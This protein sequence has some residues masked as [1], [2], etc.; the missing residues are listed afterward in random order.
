MPSRKR[1]V[2]AGRKA[3]VRLERCGACIEV[4]DVDAA[5]AGMVLADI[6]STFRALTRKYD[7]LIPDLQPVPGGS[8]VDGDASDF[9]A[10]R[11]GFTR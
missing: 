9:G 10:R 2:L 5:E 11:V 3:V 1:S 7:E 8:P 4:H 6:L